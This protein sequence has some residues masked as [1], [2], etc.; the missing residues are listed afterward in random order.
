MSAD[1]TIVGYPFLPIG[2]GEHARSTLR[3]FQAVGVAPKLVDVAVQNGAIDPD[4][5]RDFSPHVAAG[6][7]SGVNL[8]CVNGDEAG[9]VIEAVGR[10][11]FRRGY[12]IIYPAWELARYPAAW[13]KVLG[14]FDEIWAPSEFIREAIA[15]AVQ[16]PVTTMS[17]AVDL[18]LS[19]FLGRR[20]FG[21]PEDAF[22]VLFFFDFSSYAERKNPGAVL[23]AFEQLAARRPDADICCVIKSRG[24]QEADPAQLEFQARLAA[25][26]PRAQA[27]YGDLSDNE[28][29]NL[30]RV[31]DVF[32]SLHRSEGFGRG[33]AE[34]MAMGRP[35]IAT[36][37][38]GNVDFMAPGT[39]LLVDY[40]LIP[41]AKGAYPQGDGQVWA[42]AS[43]AHASTLIE[44]LMD[45][46][47]AARAMGA[48]GREH[49]RT[50]FSTTAIGRRYVE[51]LRTIGKL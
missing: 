48:R 33:M 13:A 4:L 19:A 45:D 32:V 14:E 44:G 46:P 12:N 29:K 35:A 3:A 9:R 51:R 7:G 36:G 38:S 31:C 20:H 40:E 2:M 16:K 24:G 34:A 11:A 50:H 5:D 43:A 42:D 26:A 10:D 47:A 39:S 21:I 27:I 30:V 6:L 41:V 28:I 23:A 49:I 8:F 17:L 15:Q 1:V 25:L 22:V 18:K 37:Y